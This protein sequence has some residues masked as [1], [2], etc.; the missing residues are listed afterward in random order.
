[1]IFIF[2]WAFIAIGVLIVA[3]AVSFLI[4]ARRSRGGTRKNELIARFWDFLVLGPVL[5]GFGSVY[6]LDVTFGSVSQA[7]LVV[8]IVGVTLIA[9]MIVSTIVIRWRYRIADANYSAA[10][11]FDRMMWRMINGVT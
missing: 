9:M 10:A 7:P 6:L 5:V 8:N 4:R 1:M 3:F 11:A 2:G